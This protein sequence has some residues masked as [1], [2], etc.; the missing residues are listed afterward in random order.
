MAQHVEVLMQNPSLGTHLR[1]LLFSRL[2]ASPFEWIPD[3]FAHSPHLTR[4]S[5]VQ[6]PQEDIFSSLTFERDTLPMTWAGFE[7]LAN[8]AG[9]AITIL[10]DVSIHAEADE[11]LSPFAFGQF[12]V[13]RSLGCEV[14]APFNVGIE[15]PPHSLSTVESLR[16]SA[17]H[18][19][20]FEILLR[21]E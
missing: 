20:L 16:L 11:I 9:S 15:V 14:S 17:C 8:T 2:P 10:D 19:S 7:V 1:S 21:L 6:F 13:L 18:S 12:S 4:L 3:I 5:A